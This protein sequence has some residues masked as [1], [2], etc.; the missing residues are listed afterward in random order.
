MRRTSPNGIHAARLTQALS[1]LVLEVFRLN[2]DLL[3]AGDALVGDLGL[4]SARWQVLGAV[5]LSPVPL[6]VAHVARNMGLSRQAVQRVVN[7]MC[8]EG[9]VR[10]DPNPHH[11]R[12]GLVA[13]T[14]RGEAAYATAM[15][16]QTRWAEEVTGGLA[17]EDIEAAARILRAL[18][19]RLDSMAGHTGHAAPDQIRVTQE[20]ES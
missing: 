9:L 18:Q 7:E 12:A 17:A 19:Q 10:L 6:P 3:T 8:A 20:A 4:T 2:G 1:S 11:R 13:L 15:R 14:E 5:S 16:R